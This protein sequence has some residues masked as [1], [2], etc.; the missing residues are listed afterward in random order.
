MKT[1]KCPK[2]KESKPI[3]KFSKDKTRKD[4]F[5]CWCKEH[6]KE[7]LDNY[8]KT[9]K[10]QKAILDKLYRDKNKK[11][12]KQYIRNYKKDRMD[13]DINFKITNY[14][15]TRIWSALKGNTKSLNTMFLIGCEIDYLMYHIQNQ[16]TEGMNWDNY[17]KWHI[18]H[19]KPCASF[20]L[21][22]KSEQLK[23]FN[24]TN[25]QPLWAKQNREKRNKH[26]VEN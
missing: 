9:H 15:R 21:S 5:S 8:R 26:E 10:K 22:K 7:Y 13:N 24:Y 20:D 14:L 2:C 11:K 16:F 4:G 12:L 19:K 3:S 25:L 23:C 18:D 17:G 6:C 1:K